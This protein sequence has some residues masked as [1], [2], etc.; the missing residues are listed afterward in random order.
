LTKSGA[1]LWLEKLAATHREGYWHFERVHQVVIE[2]KYECGKCHAEM[3]P[4][5]A[6]QHKIG[7][8]AQIENCTSC[9]L[10]DVAGE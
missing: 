7:R 1:R 9:H 2:N 3:K 6:S 8:V 10:G 5:R 4:F